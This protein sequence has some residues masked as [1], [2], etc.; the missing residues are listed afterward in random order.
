MKIS[1]FKRGFTLWIKK[2]HNQNGVL[3]LSQ[4]CVKKNPRPMKAF[5]VW[6]TKCFKTIR[7]VGKRQ[8]FTKGL[9]KAKSSRVVTCFFYYLTRS[10]KKNRQR[11]FSILWQSELIF[12]TAK[13]QNFVTGSSLFKKSFIL[14]LKKLTQESG[15]LQTADYKNLEKNYRIKKLKFGEQAD[16]PRKWGL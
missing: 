3:L 8:K 1:L 2:F 7:D 16:L 12:G 5:F 6:G 9:L 4:W 14:L 11:T 15:C 13:F 10:S